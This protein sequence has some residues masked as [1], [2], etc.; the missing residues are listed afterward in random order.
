MLIRDYNDRHFYPPSSKEREVAVVATLKLK[1]LLEKVPGENNQ[2]P[3]EF[4]RGE[5]VEVSFDA[6]VLLIDA[7]ENLSGGALTR[8]QHSE[9]SEKAFEK[10]QQIAMRAAQSL[11]VRLVETPLTEPAR[12]LVGFRVL[13][14]SIV[15]PHYAAYL[16]LKVIEAEAHGIELLS[17]W[18][19]PL[20]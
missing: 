3:V 8:L 17:R 1:E 13:G 19:G 14:Q 4:V 10:T 16:L 18:N 12:L 6:I 15:V 11:A 20:S 2:V 9:Y 5:I 7:L